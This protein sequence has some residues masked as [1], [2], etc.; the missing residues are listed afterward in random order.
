MRRLTVKDFSVIKEA[1]L[2]FGK[3]TVLIGPQS[4]GKSLLCKLVHFLG[5]RVTGIAVDRVVNRFEFPA[6]EAAVR[7]EFDKWFPSGG[8]GTG[9]WRI[10]FQS[11]DYWVRMTA[12]STNMLSSELVVEFAPAFKELYSVRLKKTVE[13]ELAR[14]FAPLIEGLRSLAATEFTS[15]AGRGVWDSSTYIPV[16]R[17]YFVDTTKGYRALGTEADP[18]TSQ[19]AEL[20]A[21]SLSGTTNKRRV[22]DYLGADLVSWPGGWM[23]AYRDGRFL[24]LSQ[25]SSG[26]KELLPILSVLDYYEHRRHQSGRLVSAELYGKTLYVFDDFTIEEPESSVFPKTQYDLVR[27]IAALSIET[28]FQ[29]RFTVTTHSPYI[30]SSFNNLLE[31]WQSGHMDERRCEAV[32]EVIDEKYWVNPDQFRAYSINEGYLKSIMDE[33][34]HLISDNFL[35]SVSERIGGEFDELL[36]IGYVEA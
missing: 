16:D 9:P 8:W 25:T 10:E 24:P 2:D 29:P 21:N 4:S 6:F 5:W 20:F 15:L 28:D 18:V 7:E 35:D 27:E 13:E 14:G 36:R 34:T 32:R 33:E 17:S 12:N 23:L 19:F 26:G 31:A 3:I 30:L 22:S 11:K 1:T